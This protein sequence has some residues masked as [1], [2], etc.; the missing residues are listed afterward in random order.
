MVPN[1]RVRATGLPFVFSCLRGRR[2]WLLAVVAM[3]WCANAGA[4]EIG[5]S[6]VSVAFGDARFDADVIVDPD[7]LLSKLEAF[8]G[9]P[10]SRDLSKTERDS[11]IRALAD[12]FLEQTEIRFDGHS[13][14][15]RFEYVPASAFNDL[16]QA[17]SRVRLSGPLPAGA[18]QF[19]L[20]YGLALGTYALNVRIG[21]GPVQT[22]WVVGG[23]TSEPLSLSSPPPP[24]TRLEVAWQYLTLGFTHIVPHGLDHI[25][26]V[27]GIFLL[28]SRWRSVVAQVSTFTI[29]HSITLALTMYGVV[30][31]PA[32][33]VEPMIALSI[34][35]VAIENLV[36]QELKP[37][38]LALV[39]SFG[40]LHG[41]GFAGVLRDLGLPRP[42]FVTALISFNLGVEAGQLSVIAVAFLAIAYWQRASVVR[43]VLLQ[44]DPVVRSV[45]LQADLVVGGVG[46]QLDHENAAYRR[47]VVQPA[48]MLIAAVGLFWTIQR[49]LS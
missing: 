1:Q 41:M 8:G 19:D 30:S 45:R 16:A 6:Q 33:V 22:Q 36:I 31:L 21:D 10:V 29:A 2:I 48:S 5:K 7:A 4:H 49:A 26:F 38:R 40:L 11:R 18:R 25:L 42:Q 14:R 39:F 44:A 9:R 32:R 35:Y 43:R 37:W 47:F 28:S 46:V 20:R 3:L 34:V 23:A 13:V 24:P 27:L 15:A 17:P 12:V